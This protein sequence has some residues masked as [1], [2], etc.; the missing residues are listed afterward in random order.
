MTK[1]M[2]SPSHKLSLE[3]AGFLQKLLSEGHGVINIFTG[4]KSDGQ[5]FICF[6]SPLELGRID[7]LDFMIE[8]LRLEDCKLFAHSTRFVNEENIE[9]LTIFAGGESEYWSLDFQVNDSDLILLSKRHADNPENFFQ[10][11]F[12][13]DG[14]GS[15]NAPQLLD[16]WRKVRSQIMWRDWQ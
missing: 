6:L 10:E 3:I 2:E 1:N 7:K 15:P 13:P 16:L 9:T 14:S 5:Q 8:V 12:K 4:V 11:L